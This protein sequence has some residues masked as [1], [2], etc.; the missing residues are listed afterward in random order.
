[1]FAN[2]GTRKDKAFV[3]VVQLKWCDIAARNQTAIFIDT[4]LCCLAQQLGVYH[5]TGGR[6]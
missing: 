4:Y 3:P 1:M 5:D 2:L 6:I